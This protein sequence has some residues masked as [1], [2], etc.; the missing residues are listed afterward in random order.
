MVKKYVCENNPEHIFDNLTS[1]YWCS[2]CPIEKRSMLFLKEIKVP[3]PPS[4]PVPPK[5][6]E[7]GGANIPTEPKEGQVTE[8]EIPLIDITAPTYISGGKAQITNYRKDLKYVFKPEGPTLDPQGI[9]LGLISQTSYLVYAED[10]TSNITSEPSI[11]FNV[12][13]EPELI[14]IPVINISAATLKSSGK[15]K[16]QNF[17]K[18]FSYSIEPQGPEITDEGELVKLIP[19]T[20]YVVKA[21]VKNY[22][23]PP[24]YPFSIEGKIPA[25]KK[26]EA[27]KVQQPPFIQIGSQKWAVDCLSLTE[28]SNGEKIFFAKTSSDWLKANE[29]RIPAYCL[30]C[31]DPQLANKTG[32]LYNWFALKCLENEVNK[33]QMKIPSLEE[34]KTLQ[35]TL[36]PIN[37]QPF[38]ERFYH[39]SSQRL[40]YRFPMGTF[41][42]DPETRYFWTASDNQKHYT[43]IAIKVHPDGEI[44]QKTLSKNAGFF[45]RCIFEEDKSKNTIPA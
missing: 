28:H 9:M 41:I 19:G 32:Y 29:L 24:S 39:Q 7:G 6:I 31:D 13:L 14:P 30:P 12:R 26:P 45:I 2:I 42:E 20:L 5:P 4:P 8:L 15:A 25:P 18:E 33:Q 37:K 22:F 10:L 11:P 34:I 44:Q 1:D 27:I 17:S 36:G 38:M 3:I 16:I 21:A 43:A 35:Q 40:R 23:S